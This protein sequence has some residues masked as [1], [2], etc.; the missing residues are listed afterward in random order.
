MIKCPRTMLLKNMPR[1]VE[2]KCVNILCETFG[3]LRKFR[4]IRQNR[5]SHAYVEYYSIRATQKAIES[6]KDEEIGKK[7]MNA[8]YPRKSYKDRDDGILYVTGPD[9]IDINAVWDLI[10]P[11][12]RICTIQECTR[13]K[14]VVELDD[15]RDVKLVLD[16]FKGN[17][18]YLSARRKKR[19]IQDL[20]KRF[21]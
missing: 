12:A 11:Y 20:I 8:S 18:I 3:D 15:I 7:I 4:L 16:L 6:L 2:E 13:F 9:W 1:D 19:S 17:S 10:T 5:S 14:V 21:S